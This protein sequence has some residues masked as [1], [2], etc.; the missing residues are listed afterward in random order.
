VH[1]SVRLNTFSGRLYESG[2]ITPM[3]NG[4]L[5]LLVASTEDNVFTPPNASSFVGGSTDDV[6]VASFDMQWNTTGSTGANL[7]AIVFQLTGAISPGDPVRLEWFPSVTYNPSTDY[8]SDAPP[9]GSAY[10]TFRT[11]VPNVDESTSAWFVPAEGQNLSLNFV[12]QAIGGSQ[13]ESAGYAD[14]LVAVPEPSLTAVLL[15]SAVSLG[16]R[17]CGARRP[18]AS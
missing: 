4:R 13:P 8:Q 15:V 17:R 1:A 12:T 16:L 18:L 6:V 10:G 2:G 11:D 5:L 3:Q 7:E 14:Q 9:A